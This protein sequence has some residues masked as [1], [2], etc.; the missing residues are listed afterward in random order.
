MNK[1]R[2]DIA[3]RILIEE[4][5]HHQATCTDPN[6][7]ESINITAWIGHS[8]GVGAEH[9]C[10]LAHLLEEYEAACKRGNCAGGVA[11]PKEF[12]TNEGDDN[13]EPF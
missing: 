2:L 1:Q 3:R 13:A 4:L 7:V 5:E 11:H 8:L 12:E 9:F 6:C 10:F